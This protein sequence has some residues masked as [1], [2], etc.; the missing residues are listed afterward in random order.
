LVLERGNNAG[1]LLGRRFS[2]HGRGDVLMQASQIMRSVRLVNHQ[3]I[4]FR[5]IRD[6]DALP[7]DIARNFFEIRFYL[8]RGRIFVETAVVTEKHQLESLI[9]NT[10]E[11]VHF[12][13]VECIERKSAGPF[14]NIVQL[15]TKQAHFKNILYLTGL[16]RLVEYQIDTH[17]K[18]MGDLGLSAKSQTITLYTQLSNLATLIKGDQYSRNYCKHGTY[19]LSPSSPIRAG[20][21]VAA[22][23]AKLHEFPLLNKISSKQILIDNHRLL[24]QS[25]PPRNNIFGQL[26]EY[27]L[28]LKHKLRTVHLVVWH[29]KGVEQF[30]WNDKCVRLAI[31]IN[32]EVRGLVGARNCTEINLHNFALRWFD[33]S[34]MV[35][36]SLASIKSLLGVTCRGGIAL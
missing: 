12:V 24:N 11:A 27:F 30:I 9:S 8:D 31:R 17:G 28:A 16:V 22:Q 34:P 14:E 36:V 18:V 2:L 20:L 10:D 15:F 1:A 25:Y 32:D 4:V 21:S 23:K 13:I 7:K 29:E 3:R 5:P 35:R 33:S 26:L 19:R 6:I